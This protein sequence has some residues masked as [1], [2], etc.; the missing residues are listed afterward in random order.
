MESISDIVFLFVDDEPDVLSSLRRFLHREPYR[1]MF[2]ESGLKALEIMAL[3]PVAIIVSDL[4]MPEMDGLSLL[5]EV[6]ARFPDTERLI[7][8]ATSDMDQ[9]ID[10]I[11][12]GDV[13]R[14]IQKPL[15]PV[16][17][18]EIIREA[19]DI[20]L[21]KKNDITRVSSPH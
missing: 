9:I 4:R 12:S 13:F 18:K 17:F 3:Q 19:V 5:K 16:S 6:K 10:A 15:E 14:F 21:L 1:M 2:A 11:D 7:L 8:S 20:Y